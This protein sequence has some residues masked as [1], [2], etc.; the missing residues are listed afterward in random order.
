[1]INANHTTTKGK[2]AMRLTDEQ[3]DKPNDVP[4]GCPE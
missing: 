2:R 1:M 4:G 3:K